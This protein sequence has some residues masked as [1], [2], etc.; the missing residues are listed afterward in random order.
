MRRCRILGLLTVCVVCAGP[1]L[2]VACFPDFQVAGSGVG[3]G[4]G[5]DGSFLPDGAPAPTADGSP[6][7]L[8]DGAPLPDGGGL[9]DGNP[10]GRKEGPPSTPQRRA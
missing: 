2:A 7:T 1:V 9:P 4:S 8:P 6:T 3:P 5:V 10:P